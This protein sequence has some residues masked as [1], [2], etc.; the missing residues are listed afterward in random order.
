MIQKPGQKSIRIILD[1][2]LYNRFKEVTPDY[3]DISRIIR[4]L[5]R[6][7]VKKAEV[8]MEMEGEE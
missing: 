8:E 7:Y 4:K 2:A 5:L 6:Q 3:G 1:E